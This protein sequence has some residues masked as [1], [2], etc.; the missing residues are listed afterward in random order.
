MRALKHAEVQMAHDDQW[1]LWDPFKSA[2]HLTAQ[3]RVQKERS[4]AWTAYIAVGAGEPYHFDYEAWLKM[5][6]RSH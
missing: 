6:E 5:Q 4:E 1:T 3:Q 2:D